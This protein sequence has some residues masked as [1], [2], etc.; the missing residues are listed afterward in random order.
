M[1]KN[2]V[3]KYNAAKEIYE[4]AKKK[5]FKKDAEDKVDAY[6]WWRIAEEKRGRAQ[7]EHG[8]N[9]VK[10]MLDCVLTESRSNPEKV[11]GAM[12]NVMGNIDGKL[13]LYIYDLFFP[14]TTE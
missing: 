11:T 4:K 7:D 10:T 8:R 2:L 1:K 5:K 12:C 3:T 9:L 13:Y 6:N 14:P